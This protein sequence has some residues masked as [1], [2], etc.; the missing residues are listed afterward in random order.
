MDSCLSQRHWCKV[1]ATVLVGIWTLTF[2]FDFSANN[3]YDLHRVIS[4]VSTQQKLFLFHYF[5]HMVYIFLH[6]CWI[7]LN[8]FYVDLCRMKFWTRL[9]SFGKFLLFLNILFV[10]FFLCSHM[11]VNVDWSLK[12][13]WILMCQCKCCLLLFR[14]DFIG[15]SIIVVLWLNCKW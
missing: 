9:I 12:N 2:D 14:P 1:N 10:I 3:C 7:Q 6:I 4:V 8:K 13:V 5:H 11:Q 15:I